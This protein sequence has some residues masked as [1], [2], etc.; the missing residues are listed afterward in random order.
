MS[1]PV[2]AEV[3]LRGAPHGRRWMSS[4][5]RAATSC[6]VRRV[7]PEGAAT[8]PAPSPGTPGDPRTAVPME[9]LTYS[10]PIL[11]KFLLGFDV[12]ESVHPALRPV[13]ASHVATIFK[14]LW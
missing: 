3:R 5:P 11:C 6:A 13:G 8:P 1:G 10:A 7:G 2:P 9:H 4:Q 14:N 12:L